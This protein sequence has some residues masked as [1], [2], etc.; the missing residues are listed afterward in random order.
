[1]DGY[2]LELNRVPRLKMS[3]IR[4]PPQLAPAVNRF[5]GRFGEVNRKTELALKDPDTLGVIAMVVTDQQPADRTNVFPFFPQA[6]L[7]RIS[8]NPCVEQQAD[9]ARLYEKAISIASRLK[10]DDFHN[11]RRLDE[12]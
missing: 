4:K 1:M 9:L 2:M 12:R 11:R 10:R 6:I 3:D 8:A 5:E 7:C